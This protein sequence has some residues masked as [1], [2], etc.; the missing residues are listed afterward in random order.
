MVTSDEAEK[1]KSSEEGNAGI[2]QEHI[3]KTGSG[4]FL[5]VINGS[6]EDDAFDGGVLT[7]AKEE[8]LRIPHSSS[9]RR[10]DEDLSPLRL[11]PN[12]Y[13]RCW[14]RIFNYSQ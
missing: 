4:C 10:T 8:A 9:A 1:N 3:G 6:G 12:L 14:Y 5:D 13:I 2:L 7:S 11:R